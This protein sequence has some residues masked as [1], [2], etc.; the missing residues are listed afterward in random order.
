MFMFRAGSGFAF[1]FVLAA[2]CVGGPMAHAQSAPLSYWTPGWP[3]GFGGHPAD[4][5]G[6]NI[7]AN[8][9]GFDSTSADTRFNFGNGWFVG[10][11]RGDLG[12][13]LRLG[14]SGI[15]QTGALGSFQTEGVQFGYNLMNAPVTFHAGFDT[16][17]YNPGIGG[18]V[19]PFNATSSA[20]GGYGA[21]AGVEFKPSSNLSLQFGV[22]YTQ[23]SGSL[24]TDSK[25][26]SLSNASQYD[27]VGGRH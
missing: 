5:E 14:L 12:A 26:P 9:P 10:G 4:V 20:V 11:E 1:L 13:G 7:Y 16:L 3:L 2:L 27:L 8:F 15:G 21:H 17:K 18:V 25:M 23:Q 19:A 22:G 24:D 6:A